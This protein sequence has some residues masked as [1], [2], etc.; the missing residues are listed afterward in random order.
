M[1]AVLALQGADAP[2]T[3]A[4]GSQPGGASSVD[5]RALMHAEVACDY[6][7]KAAEAAQASKLDERTRYAVAVL[8]LDQAIIESGRAAQSDTGLVELDTALQAAHAAGHAGD[9][10][11]WQ[12]ALR[13]AHAECRTVPG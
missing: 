8:L 12:R 2:G 13:T 1:F 3:T 11:G 9:H 6:L 7:S 10:D 5:A 4:D